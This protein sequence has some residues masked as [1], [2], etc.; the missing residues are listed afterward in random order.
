MSRHNRSGKGWPQDSFFGR[1][2]A[3]FDFLKLDPRQTD[4]VVERNSTNRAAIP[5]ESVSC[6]DRKSLIHRSDRRRLSVEYMHH[7]RA[8]IHRGNIGQD[9]AARRIRQY[10]DFAQPRAPAPG[11]GANGKRTNHLSCLPCQAEVHRRTRKRVT[12]PRCQHSFSP[13]T[14]TAADEPAA[15][16]DEQELPS[17]PARR[18]ASP[19]AGPRRSEKKKA[20][21]PD[22]GGR[23][24]HAG[25]HRRP[26]RQ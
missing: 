6:G 3:R 7:R 21:A 22:T 16:A 9:T 17:L 24:H 5:V 15:Q 11:R 13:G 10:S 1:N 8:R 18:A 4:F 25:R 14:P 26:V 2:D 12:C 23:R 20:A 19:S